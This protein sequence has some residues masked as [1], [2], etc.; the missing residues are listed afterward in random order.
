MNTKKR[1]EAKNEFEKD[2]FKL[3]NNSAF[4]KTMKNVRN[5]RDIKLV[6]TEKQ[7]RKLVSKLNYHTTKKFS[8][9]LLDIEMKKTKVKMNKPAYLGMS[10]LDI[11]KRLMYEFWYDYIKPNYGD[12][13]KLLSMDT[14]SF[15]IYIITD[16][17]FE[18]IADDVEKWFDT[19]N[20]DQNDKHL[21]Q[22]VKTKNQS[23]F[24]KMS[25]QERL[26]QKLLQL[27]QKHGHT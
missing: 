14:Y 1:K 18:D 22:Q 10:I 25:Q 13:T 12:R 17:I 16:D 21:S 11:S 2:F 7:R 5:H 6:T 15:V 24:L 26:L 8:E 4:G 3:M 19:S 23:V 20:Y 9:N 27:G